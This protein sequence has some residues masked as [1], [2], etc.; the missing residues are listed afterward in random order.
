MKKNNYTEPKS[1][2]PKEILKEYKLGQYADTEKE[3]EKEK[4]NKELN[5]KI[6]KF[7]KGE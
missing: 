5:D 6:R 2:F 3:K 7:V 4:R 1:Y